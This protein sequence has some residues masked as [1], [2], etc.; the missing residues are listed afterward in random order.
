MRPCTIKLL[1]LYSL[2]LLTVLGTIAASLEARAEAATCANKIRECFSLTDI[3]RDVCFQVTSRLEPC[4]GTADG[5]LAAKR[6]AYSSLLT[7]EALDSADME[8]PPEPVIFDKKCVANFDTLWLS[9]LVNDDHSAETCDH[10]LGTLNEC[11]RQ[12]S[13]DLSRP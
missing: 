1:G 7:P 6:G 8:A 5:A 3:Q 11:S 12:P 10:L 2:A 13:F 4:R 9:H